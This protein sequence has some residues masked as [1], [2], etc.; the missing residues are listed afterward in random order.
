MAT[1]LGTRY[2]L[3]AWVTV[4]T[5][6][7]RDVGADRLRDARRFADLVHGRLVELGR[8]VGVAESLTGG[9]ISVLLTEAPATSV[10]FR[11]GL[12]V[13]GTDV[14]HTIAGVRADDLTEHGAVHPVVAEQLASAARDR[15]GADYGIGATGVAGPGDQDGHPVGEVFMAI[16][17]PSAVTVNR[18]QFDGNREEVRLA[19]AAAALSDLLDVV[20]ADVEAY[21]QA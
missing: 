2:R 20:Q 18:Y 7:P 14:K 19:A 3:I 16:A 8:T 17:S 12:V 5:S 11:G 15:L 6:E 9:L 21:E 13:Y 4:T 1:G 10:T